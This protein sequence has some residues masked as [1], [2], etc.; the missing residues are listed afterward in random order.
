MHVT[1]LLRSRFPRLLLVVVALGAMVLEAAE[2][3]ADPGSVQIVDTQ[4][5]FAEQLKPAVWTPVRLVLSSD[6]VVGDVR[7]IIGAVDN[8]G[9][10]ARF[11]AAEPVTL[12]AGESTLWRY[13]RVGDVNQPVSITVEDAAGTVLASRQVRIADNVVSLERVWVIALG[14]AVGIDQL[15]RGNLLDTS[16]TVDVGIVDG[17]ALPDSAY[18]YEGVDL[19]VI[20]AG[21]SRAYKDATP[22]QVAALERWLERGGRILITAGGQFREAVQAAPWLARLAGSDAESVDVITSTP[23]A[24]EAFVSARHPLREFEAAQLDVSGI[25]RLLAGRTKDLEAFP[26]IFE[27]LHGFGRVMV[28]AADFDAAPFAGWPE[29]TRVLSEVF[30]QLLRDTRAQEMPTVAAGQEGYRDLAGQLS[31]SL[32]QPSGGAVPFSWV[33]GLMLLYIGLIGPL[34]YVVINRWLGRPLLG[35]ATFGVAILIAAIGLAAWSAQVRTSQVRVRGIEFIDIV[36]HDSVARANGWMRVHSGPAGGYD[37]R[38]D[39]P[40]ARL[41]WLGIAGPV[42]GGFEPPATLIEPP[43][44]AILAGESHAEVDDMPIARS[45][46]RGLELSWTPGLELDAE[47]NLERIPGSDLVR[48]S[49]R[50]PLKQDLLEAA[51]IY[52]NRIYLLP[53]RLTPGQEVRELDRLNQKNFAWRLT[54]RQLLQG[55]SASEPWDTARTEDPRR[56][57]EVLQFHELAGGKKYTHLDNRPLRHLDLSYFLGYD[58]AILMGRI[59][60]SDAR[61][62]VDGPGAVR[63]PTIETDVFVRIVYPVASANASAGTE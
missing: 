57:V 5:G 1:H 63:D 26:L 17:S 11:A 22:D 12:P 23:G 6:T 32:D 19:V 48:G 33:A 38:V 47:P 61:V 51:L 59:A 24:I 30:P 60:G 39:A 14:D 13:I 40:D 54:R 37:A 20:P 53:T 27:R 42:F 50:N 10:L 25:Q 4:I 58:R 21:Q 15:G 34:D 16:G 31:A 46:S 2:P 55:A 28:F 56:V 41:A 43:P 8:R 7:V 35:W 36:P 9:G 49:V 18:G 3:P 62:T 52:R 29:R 45:G 44:Y